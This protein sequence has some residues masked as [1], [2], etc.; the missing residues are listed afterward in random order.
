M[1]WTLVQGIQMSALWN[2]RYQVRNTGA[3]YRPVFALDVR[4][5]R[6]EP[7]LRIP[8][9]TCIHGTN[10]RTHNA[11]D[12]AIGEPGEYTETYG[13]GRSRKVRTPG[14]WEYVSNA[15]QPSSRKALESPT[16]LSNIE[17]IIRS[18]TDFTQLKSRLDHKAVWVSWINGAVLGR[19]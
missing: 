18:H 14:S 17:S 13:Y 9:E 4:D 1:D 3:D 12:S 15:V 5:G 19:V 6:P 11:R 2:H 7:R 8:H 10:H 16:A